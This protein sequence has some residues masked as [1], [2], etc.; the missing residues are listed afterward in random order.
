MKNTSAQAYTNADAIPASRVFSFKLSKYLWNG[1]SP[2]PLI[3][4]IWEIINCRNTPLLTA[5][6]SSWESETTKQKRK[7]DPMLQAG[8]LHVRVN[9]T[10]GFMGRKV[11]SRT[12]LSCPRACSEP[13]WEH[14]IPVYKAGL[15]F[16]NDP[17]WIIFLIRA[18]F[19]GSQTAK[20]VLANISSLFQY[21]GGGGRSIQPFPAP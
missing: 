10:N 18:P 15:C 4:R 21:N 2:S 5:W 7:S 9:M 14:G 11:P 13:S 20:G 3:E 8:I 1:N 16:H 17:E 12:S 6:G 19:M